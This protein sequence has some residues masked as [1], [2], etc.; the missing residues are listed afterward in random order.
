MRIH[1]LRVEWLQAASL[2]DEGLIRLLGK[3]K[4]P[5]K[6]SNR[7]GETPWQIASKI[8]ARYLQHNAALPSQMTIALR[9][10]DRLVL[11]KDK[12]ACPTNTLAASSLHQL[13]ECPSQCLDAQCT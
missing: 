7:A 12:G 6:V 9:R 11:K 10:H 3:H 1:G 5:F 13:L 8:K 2:Q 4:V